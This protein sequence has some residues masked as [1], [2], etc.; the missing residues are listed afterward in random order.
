LAIHE[1]IIIDVVDNGLT[2]ATNKAN[3][4]N[5]ATKAVGETTKAMAGEMRGASNSVLENGGAMGLL[6]DLTGGYAIIKYYFELYFYLILVQTLH[7]YLLQMPV[8]VGFD[9]L[10]FVRF[11]SLLYLALN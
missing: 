2:E 9:Y 10:C 5:K 7:Y 1:E 4:L 8:S 3:A 6:N 11:G